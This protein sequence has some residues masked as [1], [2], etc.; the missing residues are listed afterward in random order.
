MK[1]VEY[2]GVHGRRADI[3]MSQR[4]SRRLTNLTTLIGVMHLCKQVGVDIIV[5]VLSIFRKVWQAKC[6]PCYVTDCAYG[7]QK[8]KCLCD[9]FVVEKGAEILLAPAEEVRRKVNAR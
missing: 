5:R 7:V 2:H 6:L 8:G 3:L 9:T 4:R 1:T